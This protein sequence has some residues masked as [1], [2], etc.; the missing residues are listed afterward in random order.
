MHWDFPEISLLG[1]GLGQKS[2]WEMGIGQNLG[3]E[4]GFIPPPPPPPFRTLFLAADDQD[5]SGSQLENVGHTFSS[6]VVVSKKNPSLKAIED[7]LS[8]RQFT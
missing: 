6:C 3:W 5:E 7:L 4:M 8:I 2:G 1:L